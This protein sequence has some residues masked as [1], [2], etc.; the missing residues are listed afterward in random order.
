ME[1]NQITPT[2]LLNKDTPTHS[3]VTKFRKIPVESINKLIGK[4]RPPLEKDS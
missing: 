2:Y 4:R 3:I 1:M